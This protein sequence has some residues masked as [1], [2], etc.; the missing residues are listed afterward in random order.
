MNVTPFQPLQAL[1]IKIAL[2]NIKPMIWRRILVP[3]DITLSEFHEYIQCAMEW[4]EAHLH[5]F[6][7]VDKRIFVPVFEAEDLDERCEDESQISLVEV[8]QKKGDKLYYCYDFGDNWEH[9]ITVEKVRPIAD[10]D[11]Y[12][13]CLGGK[14]A[15]PPEDCG[16]VPGYQRL[17]KILSTP[18]HEEYQEVK[19]WLG[20]FYNPEYF[21][22][23]KVNVMFEMDGSELDEYEGMEDLVSQLDVEAMLHNQATDIVLRSLLMA[24]RKDQPELYQSVKAMSQVQATSLLQG[25]VEAD[26]PEAEEMGEALIDIVDSYFHVDGE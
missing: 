5:S 17:I 15:C 14:R 12:D 20:D 7:S 19:E 2:N 3:N 24:L 23:D 26:I 1:Q 9:T 25:T 11:N 13:F 8:L 10:I 21:D 18:T 16:G 4:E 6:T 22:I